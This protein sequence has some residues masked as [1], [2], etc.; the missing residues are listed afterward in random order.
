MSCPNSTIEPLSGCSSPVIRLN[1]VVLP[2]PFG[3]MINRRSPGAID[4]L[5]SAVT[6]SPP[7]DLHNALT[8]SAVMGGFL[9]ARAT[10]LHGI[11]A[12]VLAKRSATVALNRAP[13]LPA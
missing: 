13:A 12:E 7:N 11:A 10:V 6:R 3:P 4:R 1:S 5:T 9:Q 8:P 2:A